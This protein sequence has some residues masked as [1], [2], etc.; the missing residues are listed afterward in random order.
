MFSANVGSSMAYVWRAIAQSAWNL[1]PIQ[2]YMEQDETQL[3]VQSDLTLTRKIMVERKGWDWPLILKILFVYISAQW[4]NTSRR[5]EEMLTVTKDNESNVWWN[6]V[7]YNFVNCC[8][9]SNL[10][11]TTLHTSC[12]VL[13]AFVHTT[14]VN[15]GL[16]AASGCWG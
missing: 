2:F 9:S 1:L 7:I 10:I 16:I 12:P 4:K 6:T 15:F 8:C 5:E 3:C 13:P 11:F 14:R